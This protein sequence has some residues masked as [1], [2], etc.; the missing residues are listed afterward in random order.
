MVMTE[1]GGNV[2]DVGHGAHVDPGLRHGNDDIGMA[3][4]Q[5]RQQ[6]DLRGRIGDL[7]AHKIF[8]GDAHVG[9]AL[10]ELLDDL[11]GREESHFDARQFG[12]RAAIVARAAS[13]H[14]G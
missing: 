13:L 12:D 1:R 9:C 5:R 6:F 4:A 10:G 14:D 11:G 7:L 3:E 8:T 2:V